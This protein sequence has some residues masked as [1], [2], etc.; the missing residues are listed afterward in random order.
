MLMITRNYCHLSGSKTTTGL[1]IVI[2]QYVE[3]SFFLVKV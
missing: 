1:E 3:K 2:K